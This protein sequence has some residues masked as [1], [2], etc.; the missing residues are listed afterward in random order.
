MQQ[1]SEQCLSVTDLTRRI[2]ASLESGF[3]QVAVRGEIS[4]LRRQA[5]GHVYFSLKDSGAA[6]SCVCF[7]GDAA[8]MGPLFRDGLQVRAHGRIAVYEPRGNYQLVVRL[9]EADGEGRLQQQ[10]LELKRRLEAEGL[11]ARERKQ[12]L[13]GLPTRVAFVT[14]DSGAA[15]RDFISVLRRRNWAG[16]LTVIPARVQGTGAATEIAAGIAAANRHN[17]AD[18]IVVGRG[19]G[20]LEDLWPFNEEA[21]ARAIAASALPVISAVG[22]ETDITLSDFAADHR[23]ETP[24][25]AA[26]LICSTR[27]ALLNRFNN[28]AQHLRLRT[29]HGLDRKHHRFQLARAELRRLHPQHRLEQA[30]LRLDDLHGRLGKALEQRLNDSRHQLALILNRFHSLHPERQLSHLRDQL[31]Q[32]S[33]RLDSASHRSALRRGYAV[34]RHPQSGTVIS[35]AANVPPAAPFTIELRDGA[36]TATR[37]AD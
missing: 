36:I 8:R 5:S 29:T 14:S 12:A 34:L 22:H 23:A 4:N 16:C 28:A 37:Q 33:I 7:R 10:F 26:E 25:A 19:G 30:M 15:L 1:S 11:F 13:P 17:I 27:E 3:P 32:I 31:R 24:T 9:L 35:D 2:K 20:S 21:V 18:V 6:L